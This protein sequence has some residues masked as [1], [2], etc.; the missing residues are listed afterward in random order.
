[1]HLQPFHLITRITLSLIYPLYLCSIPA[2]ADETH[3]LFNPTP[4]AAMRPMSTER[5]SK[6]DS[7]YSLDAGH[8]QIET[9]LMGYMRNDDCRQDTCI[10]T[11]QYEIGGFNN[12]RIGLLDDMDLQIVNDLYLNKEDTLTDVSPPIKTRQNNRGFGDTQ[13]RLKYNLF[14]NHPTDKYSLA[15]LPY[16]KLA[17]HSANLGNQK[18]EWGIGVPFNINLNSNWSLGGMTVLNAIND[19]QHRGYD[20]AYANALVLGKS[21]STQ[22]RTYIELYSYKAR[23]PGERFKN[24]M[25]VGLIYTVN[26]NCSVD[27]NIQKGISDAADDIKLFVGVAYRY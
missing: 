11:R 14:G 24:T 10:R 13:V 9:N 23:Q 17:T 20:F 21:L 22:L 12:V 2:Y 19:E 15:L 1:M 26:S 27:A 18:I 3:T 16:I 6:T 5:P 7:P 8:V 4:A 25:D